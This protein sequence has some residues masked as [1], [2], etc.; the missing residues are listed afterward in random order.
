MP[1]FVRG[2][3]IAL[4]QVQTKKLIPDEYIVVFNDGEQDP[5]IYATLQKRYPTRVTAVWIRRVHPDPA[6]VRIEGQND[7]AELLVPTATADNSA[8]P[9]SSP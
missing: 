8:R 7:F 6:R 4:N 3:K 9:E 2:P 5:E 1:R